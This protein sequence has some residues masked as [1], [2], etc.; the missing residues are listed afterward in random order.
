MSESFVG[1]QWEPENGLDPLELELQI[2]VPAMWGL[3]T[4]PK[5]SARPVSALNHQAN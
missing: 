1:C 3:G 2:A 4:E 5:T